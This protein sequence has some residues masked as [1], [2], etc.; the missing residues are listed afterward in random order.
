MDTTATAFDVE[1]F[2][3]IKMPIHKLAPLVKP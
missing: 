2:N 1:Y 3:R